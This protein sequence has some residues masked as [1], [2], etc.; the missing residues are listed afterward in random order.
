MYTKYL[1]LLFKTKKKLI[2]DV[3]KINKTFNL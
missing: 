2:W 1:I 3:S